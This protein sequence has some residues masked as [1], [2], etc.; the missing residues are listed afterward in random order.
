MPPTLWIIDEQAG[1]ESLLKH[2]AT[3]IRSDPIGIF[4]LVD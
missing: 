1:Q 3:P 4:G 2:G